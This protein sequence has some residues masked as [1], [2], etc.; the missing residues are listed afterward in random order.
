MKKKC[1]GVFLVKMFGSERKNE[2]IVKYD[3][4]NLIELKYH[5]F[6]ILKCL[7]NLF[8]LILFD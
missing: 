1:V 3:K 7:S 4:I 2:N 5:L 8:T 6:K